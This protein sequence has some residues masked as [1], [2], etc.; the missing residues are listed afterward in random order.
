MPAGCIDI[1]LQTLQVYRKSV[2]LVLFAP[3]RLNCVTAGFEYRPRLPMPRARPRKRARTLEPRLKELAAFLLFCDTFCSV[4]FL[5][6]LQKRLIVLG[7]FIFLCE[8]EGYLKR[9]RITDGFHEEVVCSDKASRL[10]K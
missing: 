4:C 9:F 8:K 1:F 10:R 5:Q 6:Y 3:V 7:I 2:F